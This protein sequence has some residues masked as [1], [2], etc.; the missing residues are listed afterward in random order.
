MDFKRR[1]KVSTEFS[2]ASMS[3]MIFLLLIFFLIT[4]T[5]VSPNGVKIVLPKA[6]VQAPVK[7]NVVVSVKPDLTIYINQEQTTIDRLPSQLQTE[8]SGQQDPV[9][10]IAADKTVPY[11]QVMEVIKVA[12]KLKYKI[13]LKTIKNNGCGSNKA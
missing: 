6:G 8:L 3:D 4:S 7:Q 1:S 5:M 13:L 12:T 11:E 2:L 10:A 9:V